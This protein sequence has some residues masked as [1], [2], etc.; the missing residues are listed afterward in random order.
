MFIK[1]LVLAVLDLDEK[2]RIKVDASD[3]TTEEVLS[4]EYK[5]IK[6]KPVAFLSKFLNETERNYCYKTRVWTDFG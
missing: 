5:D 6:W 1:E 4:I 2:M 3:Y